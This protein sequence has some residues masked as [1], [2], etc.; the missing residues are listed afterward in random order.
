MSIVPSA[1]TRLVPVPIPDSVAALIG[2]C[3]PIHILQAEVDVECAAREVRSFRPLLGG[4][5][6]DSGDRRNREQALAAVARANK[7]LAA[8]NPLLILKPGG[9][10][11]G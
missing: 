3:M 1:S 2:S 11:R 8:Y 4:A 10:C 6:L 7:V 9:G 5:L